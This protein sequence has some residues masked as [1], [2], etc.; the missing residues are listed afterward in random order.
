MV[1]QAI[2]AD[3]FYIYSH[4][5]ALSNARQRFDVILAGTNPTDPFAEW[6]DIGEGLRQA[7]RD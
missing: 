6:P 5:K 2:R 3:Q 1:F 7:L 4:T